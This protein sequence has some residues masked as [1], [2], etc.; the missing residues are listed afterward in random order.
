MFSERNYSIDDFAS[1]SFKDMRSCVNT[2]R[3]Q[4]L[5][6]SQHSFPQMR[7]NGRINEMARHMNDHNRV[8]R[9]SQSSRSF[10]PGDY[11][12]YLP[13]YDDGSVD[14]VN[15]SPSNNVYFVPASPPLDYQQLLAL[16]DNNSKRG[17]SRRVLDKLMQ[18]YPKTAEAS[19]ECGICKDKFT[20]HTKLMCLPC[21]HKYHM[22]CI[23]QWFLTNRTCPIC[24]FEVEP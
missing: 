4:H 11:M 23:T 9:R 5:A 10:E 13:G 17:V 1:M 2:G 20:R 8:R 19:L 22:K 7:G 21:S 15:S 12:L 6:L 16:D 24:R 3:L 14:L 18:R